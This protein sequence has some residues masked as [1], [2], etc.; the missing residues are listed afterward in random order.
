MAAPKSCTQCQTTSTAVWRIDRETKAV[1]C[2]PCY[3]KKYP[4]PL[5]KCS[6][7]ENGNAPKRRKTIELKTDG[8]PLSEL[9]QEQDIKVQ[10]KAEVKEEVK[11]EIKEEVEDDAKQPDSGLSDI[12]GDAVETQQPD[13]GLNDIFGA[14]VQ[15]RKKEKRSR[16]GHSAVE[17]DNGAV[18]ENVT[19][20]DSDT[21]YAA[22]DDSAVPPSVIVEASG[23]SL[24]DGRYDRMPKPCRG[25]PCYYKRFKDKIVYMYFTK[26]WRLGSELGSTRCNA[27][28]EDVK[29]L[30]DCCE[31]YPHT[32]NVYHKKEGQD[33]G[34]Y[35]PVVALRVFDPATLAHQPQLPEPLQEA[36]SILGKASA[37]GEGKH[38]AS[39]RKREKKDKKEKEKKESAQDVKLEK[40]DDKKEEAPSTDSDSSNS[41]SASSDS[42]DDG[43]EIK[44]EPVPGSAPNGVSDAEKAR[45]KKSAAE[46]AKAQKAQDF[47]QKLRGAM[48]EITDPKARNKKLDTIRNMLR[49]KKDSLLQAAGMTPEMIDNLVIELER[50]FA[51][52]GLR[53]PRQPTGQPP[54]HL[55]KR[56]DGSGRFENAMPSTPPE[57]GSSANEP[58]H[59]TAV[60]VRGVLKGRG[61]IQERANFRMSTRQCL[62]PLEMIPVT[63]FR[64]AGENLWFQAP[65]S[66][67]VCDSCERGVPQTMG[68]LKGAADR[69]QFAQCEFLCSDCMQQGG[70]IM[71]A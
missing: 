50:D 52:T 43:K 49:A 67:V 68:A 4:R 36:A 71:A 46:E 65:G 48:Q 58:D 56:E 22:V 8:D 15:E 27:R 24:L 16:H 38:E 41:S 62:P 70:M 21:E 47:Q 55:L 53:A 51:T 32:W 10:I 9:A 54:A 29:G 26:M 25:R 64:S 69:S 13:N 34:V 45:A 6:G 60:P 3:L 63:S 17:Q 5:T 57:N 37:D 18:P 59:R 19:Y 12:F 11:E 28:I 30:M 42:S 35:E 7:E 20:P 61:R 66:V 23:K 44:Q 33:E 39:E 14:A 2:N 40:Q 1:M 31:P